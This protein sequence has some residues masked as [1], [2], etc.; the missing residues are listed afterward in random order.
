MQPI[1][2]IIIPTY[3]HADTL[4]A[5]V[6][7]ALM[8]TVREIEIFIVGDGV[9]NRTREVVM[10]LKSDDRV[11]FVDRPKS[12][13][14]G[15]PY[16]HEILQEV[17]SKIVCYLS[18]DDLYFPDH[19]EHMLRLLEN[20]DFATTLPL[21]L[22]E[23]RFQVLLADLSQECNREVQARGLNGRFGLPYA[24]HTLD[25]YR[26]L[27]HGWRTTP[28]DFFTDQ[29]MWQQCL[30]VPDCKSV[31]SFIPTVLRFPAPTRK[32]LNPLQRRAELDLWLPK[33]LDPLERDLLR[34]QSM[35][36]AIQSGAKEICE[37]TIQRYDLENALHASH[38]AHAAM[39]NDLHEAYI[40]HTAL[41][42]DLRES[43]AA[44][45][46]L[47]QRAELQQQL[48]IWIRSHA[49]QEQTAMNWQQS[50]DE[51]L[52]QLK[53]LQNSRTQK[54]ANLFRTHK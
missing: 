37:A 29:Y 23:G 49:V 45:A 44:Q 15:E 1:A 22:D 43:K 54:L 53:Q 21:F 48:E 42:T 40:S 18:D 9:P 31:S 46:A 13:R 19:V 38:V 17:K 11:R 25:F 33:L 36:H 20:A 39:E 5:S 35:T 6:K 7:S 34:Q 14:T 32:H 52:C 4:Y 26:R 2:T 12:P 50:S 3:D 28:P 16:R 51:L 47:I 24:A 41:E 27:P 8:Q 30:S 10:D